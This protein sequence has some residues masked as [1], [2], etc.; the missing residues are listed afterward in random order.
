MYVTVYSS[1]PAHSIYDIQ[2][3]VS[4]ESEDRA[5]SLEV[6]GIARFRLLKDV[7]DPSISKAEARK[8]LL[9]ARAIRELNVLIAA[10][11]YIRNF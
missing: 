10:K 9:D 7:K 1:K 2:G 8:D 6:R 11:E 3:L 4:P 5:R